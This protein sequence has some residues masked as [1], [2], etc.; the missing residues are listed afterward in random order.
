MPPNL[1]PSHP[2]VDSLSM[3]F[4][5]KISLSVEVTDFETTKGGIEISGQA[6]QDSGALATFSEVVDFARDATQTNDGWFVNVTAKTIPPVQFDKDEEITVFVRVA[7]VWVTVL[8]QGAD[9]EVSGSGGDA[10]T[11][12]GRVKG[13]S[14]LI[15]KSWQEWRTEQAEKAQQ[16][17]PQS[18]EEQQ[19]LANK[20]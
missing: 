7:R 8:E 20:A 12:W 9:T 17:E 2:Y 10:L 15:G 16:A 4:P 18:Q 3:A 1:D 5:D 6:T 11:K 13:S 19:V 14:Q